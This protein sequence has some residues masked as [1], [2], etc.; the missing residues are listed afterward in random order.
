[1]SA[2]GGAFP[3]EEVPPL[4]VAENGEGGASPAPASPTPP[5]ENGYIAHEE[6]HGD[7]QIDDRLLR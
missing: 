4:P 3:E 2:D 1:M 6:A 7:E 5:E